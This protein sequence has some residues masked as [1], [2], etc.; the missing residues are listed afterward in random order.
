MKRQSKLVVSGVVV[1][2]IAV[3]AVTVGSTS[4]D[5]MQPTELRQG[6]HDGERVAVEGRV[7]DLEVGAEVHFR[8]AGNN[9]TTVPVVMGEDKMAPPT[10]EAGRIVIVKGTYEDDHVSARKVVVRAH[11]ST[12]NRPNATA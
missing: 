2:F 1:V 8:L 10:L 12:G 4:T 11:N 6:D 9:S 7:T 3:M 5:R